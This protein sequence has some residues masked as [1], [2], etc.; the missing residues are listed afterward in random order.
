[1]DG[2]YYAVSLAQCCHLDKKIPAVTLVKVAALYVI[3][4][5]TY[6]Q[7]YVMV[8]STPYVIVDP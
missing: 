3:I 1:M 7:K 8:C 2:R 6:R 4:P 5:R